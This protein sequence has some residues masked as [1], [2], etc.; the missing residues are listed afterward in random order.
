MKQIISF[1]L[2][3]FCSY[4]YSGEIIVHQGESIHD[5]LQ[6]AR[7]WRRTNDARCQG[8]ITITLQEGRFYM[9]EPLFLRPEDS[10]TK[11]SPLVIRGIGEKHTSVICGDA[12]QRHTQLWPL[13]EQGDS[14][15]FK[16]HD[17][18]LPMKGMERIIDFNT[19][20]RTITIPTPPQNVL[21]TK[22]LEMVVHQ[23]WAIAIL[24][25][26]E[27]KVVGDKTIVSFMEPESR[28]EFDH[29][30]STLIQRKT[31]LTKETSWSTN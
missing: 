30:G 28:L 12:R 10:G 3:F 17:D 14:L 23:R 11:E 9:S 18:G 8:G 15:P 22:N 29:P 24:R 31:N 21:Q 6:Q 4:A 1:F 16:K 13:K 25:V 19:T 20:D 7:E 5:A 27:M 2:C 26:K